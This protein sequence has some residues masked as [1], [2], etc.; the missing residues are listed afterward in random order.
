MLTAAQIDKASRYLAETRDSLVASTTTLSSSQWDFRPS[1]SCW[2]IAG[3]VEH[4]ALI[5]NRVHATIANMGNAPDA[6]D[7]GEQVQKDDFILAAVPDRSTKG[8]AP[9]PVC[10]ARRWSGP[11]A[12]AQFVTSREQTIELL[13]APFLRGHVVPHPFF[14]PWDGYQW[15][16]AAAAHTARHTE[17]VRE[18]TAHASF[19]QAYALPQAAFV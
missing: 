9:P 15:I 4:L 19:P 10:P 13:S 8:Q 7:L 3:I 5:E 18:V 1:T 2:S 6:A 16:L 11:E 17:Q 14:G 12:L